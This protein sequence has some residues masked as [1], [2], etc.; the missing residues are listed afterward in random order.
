MECRVLAHQLKNLAQQR[1]CDAPA[2]GRL[3][4]HGY[5]GVRSHP[6]RDVANLTMPPCGSTSNLERPL[7]RVSA[8]AVLFA[9]RNAV[10][11]RRQPLHQVLVARPLPYR[12]FSPRSIAPSASAATSGHRAS[13]SGRRLLQAGRADMAALPQKDPR[14]IFF[15]RPASLTV[16]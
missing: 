6:G 7:D 5:R 14:V 10:E 2:L 11:T 9:T 4:L 16:P 8:F 3:G 12:G 1:V 15:C 13:V